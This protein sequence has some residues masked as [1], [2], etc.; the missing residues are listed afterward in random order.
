MNLPSIQGLVEVPHEAALHASGLI[1]IKLPGEEK[2]RH[3]VNNKAASDL[4]AWASA[5]AKEQLKPAPKPEP[6]VESKPEPK[7]E[8]KVEVKPEPK[9]TRKGR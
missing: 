5:K 4:L 3:F 2:T 8:P 6:K 7:P 9:P 1:G